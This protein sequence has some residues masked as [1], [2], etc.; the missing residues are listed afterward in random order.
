[1]NSTHQISP[2]TKSA[3]FV[4]SCAVI[5][6]K[7][8]VKKRRM[9]SEGQSGNRTTLFWRCAE[10]GNPPRQGMNARLSLL[11]ELRLHHPPPPPCPHS[12]PPGSQG[13]V[14][15]A[16]PLY[17]WAIAIWEESLGE[18]D[19]QVAIG[20]SNMAVA[21]SIQVR[22]GKSGHREPS[23]TAAEGTSPFRLNV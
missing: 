2:R 23:T 16:E 18:E 8:S 6:S 21:C 5:N 10:D 12:R 19:C 13:K 22:E 4:G 17:A 9:T 1:M 20:L 15:E 11:V 3:A 14:Q 7:K